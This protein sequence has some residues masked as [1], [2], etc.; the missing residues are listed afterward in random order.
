MAFW[1][2]QKGEFYIEKKKLKKFRETLFT[3]KLHLAVNLGHI[4]TKID[5]SL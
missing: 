4:E 5:L 2:L 1:K 3:F